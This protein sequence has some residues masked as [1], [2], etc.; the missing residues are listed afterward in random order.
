MSIFRS[1]RNRLIAEI[2]ILL[3]G[4]LAARLSSSFPFLEKFGY[5]L[6]TSAMSAIVFELILKND[7]FDELRTYLHPKLL[8]LDRRDKLTKYFREMLIGSTAVEI[9]ALTT[10]KLVDNL[11][12]D[13]VKKL[14][15][16]R[17][18]IEILMLHPRS[19]MWTHRLT[20]EPDNDRQSL[21]AIQRRLESWYVALPDKLRRG[22][23]LGRLHCR[24]Y[25]SIPYF[26]YCRG[27]KK[28]VIG[29][30]TSTKEGERTH[31]AVTES[32]DLQFYHD[33][34]DHFHH[35]WSTSADG[36][37]LSISERGVHVNA[38]K[39]VFCG[40]DRS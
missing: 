8:V 6:A 31:A 40:E 7:L 16:E 36:E 38:D 9:I 10:E 30:L 33:F 5:A 25:D 15:T 18:S 34:Q 21:E 4:L 32:E 11:G 39:L 37:F 12:D 29:F 3:I 23:I 2:F 27:D 19:P 28:V 14:K 1:Q 20:H 26:S 24:Y 22:Q 13:I 17:C 35:L